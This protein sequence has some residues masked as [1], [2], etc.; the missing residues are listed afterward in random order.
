M[1]I[2]I[3][4]F[5]VSSVESQLGLIQL[6]LAVKDV[7]IVN[8]NAYAHGPTEKQSLTTEREKS[9]E[10]VTLLEDRGCLKSILSI[11]KEMN[12]AQSTSQSLKEND[13]TKEII[14]VTILH[15]WQVQKW[16]PS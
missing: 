14:G 16:R 2:S 13:R 4:R 3:V 15:E 12:L 5:F 9:N 1:K 8:I 6:L 11:L 10:A 7:N